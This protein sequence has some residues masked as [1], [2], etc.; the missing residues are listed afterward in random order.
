[1]SAEFLRKPKTKRRNHYKREKNAAKKRFIITLPIIAACIWIGLRFGA[2]GW[3]IAFG[4]AGIAAS[5][6]TASSNRRTRTFTAAALLSISF[7]VY[8]I[9]CFRLGGERAAAL[10]VRR[11]ITAVVLLSAAWAIYKSKKRLR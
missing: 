3:L 5:I 1:L 11:I 2:S 8:G 6:Y 10:E 9:Y 4:L 7:I